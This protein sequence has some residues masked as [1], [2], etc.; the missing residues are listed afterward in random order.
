MPIS[1]SAVVTVIPSS[2]NSFK[3]AVPGQMV[4]AMT[5]DRGSGVFGQLGHAPK[6]I[7][8]HVKVRTSRNRTEEYSYEIISDPFLTPLLINVTVYN[9]ITASERAL[10]DSTIGIRGQIEVKG[11]KPVALERRFSSNSAAL[12]A[13]GSVAQPVATL[14]TSGFDGVEISNLSLDITSSDTKNTAVLERI[15]L[16][17]TEVRRGETIE[18]QAYGRTESGKQFVERI[19]VQ[20]PADVGRGQLIVFVGDGSSLQEATT[21]KTLVPRDLDQLVGEINKIKKNDRLYVKLYRATPGVVIGASELPDLPPSV[22][23]TLTNDRSAGGY[24]PLSLSPVYEKE[25]P[26]AEFVIV[27]EHSIAIEVLP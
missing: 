18:I 23:A 4:G 17:R 25:L 16:D 2:Y 11:Q 15:S 21:Q 9:S 22:V 12:S 19:P 20:I 24:T 3:L 27:G 13:A 26:P 10:G 8:V 1:E 14:L 5:Q 6:M 7:P